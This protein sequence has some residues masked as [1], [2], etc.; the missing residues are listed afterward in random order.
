MGTGRSEFANVQVKQCPLREHLTCFPNVI[1]VKSFT[2]FTLEL[3]FEV[4]GF[5]VGMGGDGISGAGERL[6]RDVGGTCLAAGMVAGEGST[7]SG[8]GTRGE[9]LVE[10]GDR[11]YLKEIE[12]GGV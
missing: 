5:A 6:G 11:G 4:G 8:G 7:G 10:V 9:D 12:S 2:F 3:V 1:N